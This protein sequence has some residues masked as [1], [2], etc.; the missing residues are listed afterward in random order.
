VKIACVDKT[1]SDR[2]QLQKFVDD[3][4]EECRS[5]IG[6]LALP[7]SIPCT[8]EDLLFGSRPDAAILGA[9]W[10]LEESYLCCR[11]VRQHFPELPLYVI[12][13][14]AN[15]SLRALRRFENVCSEVLTQDEPPVRF[16]HRLLS[17]ENQNERK[18]GKLLFVQGVKGGVGATSIACGLAHAAQTAGH[19]AVIV[20]LS[21][22]SAVAHYLTAER[23]Q[24]ADYASLVVDQLAPDLHLVNKLLTR[25]PNGL[26]LL[27]PPSG[28]TEVRELWL[29]DPKRFELT[30]HVI[31]LLKEQFDVVIVDA[32]RTEGILPFALLARADARLLVTSNEAAAVHLLTQSIHQLAEL[33]GQKLSRVLINLSL[34]RG[35]K[36]ADIL[37][38]LPP[39]ET[40]PAGF[41]DLPPLALDT[42]AR[43]WIGSGNTIYTEGS[44]TTQATL[45][46]VFNS[47]MIA[48]AATSLAASSTTA[49]SPRAK[50]PRL[51]L[52]RG[53][54]K[55]KST[56]KVLESTKLPKLLPLNLVPPPSPLASSHFPLYQGPQP[57]VPTAEERGGN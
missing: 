10:S 55:L 54:G 9:G 41:C 1:A 20:D 53:F 26:S 6:H 36:K 21:P 27:L 40:L 47:L 34:E 46:E 31:E 44:R 42:A 38:F 35:L 50:E 29:R 39:I 56:A 32:A 28:G 4:Y 19:D 2:L 7:Q 48:P 17:H 11:D 8:K 25:A 3:A 57:T 18:R 49:F 5:A 23:W 15:F 43:H 52:W 14:P 22:E 30:L 13:S 37:A 16:V 12:L 24:S 33:P 45:E 51:S